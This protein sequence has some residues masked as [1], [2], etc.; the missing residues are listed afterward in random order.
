MT[1]VLFLVALPTIVLVELTFAS[2]LGDAVHSLLALATKASHVMGSSR[3]SEH[4]KEKAL[5]AYALRMSGRSLALGAWLLLLVSSYGIVL[6]LAGSLLIPGFDARRAV[7]RPDLALYTIVFAGL[8]A[9]ARR[10][11]RRA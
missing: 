8:Y 10:R 4:W 1:E 5:L 6:H 9:W 3:I 2:R 11:A 7:R